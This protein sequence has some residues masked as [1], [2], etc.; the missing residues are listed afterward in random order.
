MEEDVL[1]GL[2]LSGS[3]CLE[4]GPD[5]IKEMGLEFFIRH[6]PVVDEGVKAGGAG[7]I[8]DHEQGGVRIGIFIAGFCGPLAKQLLQA[9]GVV[10]KAGCDIGAEDTHG[11]IVP[12]E[13]Q[14]PDGV[15]QLL[16]HH[17]DQENDG[18]L[19][20]GDAGLFQFPGGFFKKLLGFQSD[21]EVLQIDLVLEVQIEG[22]LG[23]ACL[24]GNLGHGH[25]VDVLA[26]KQREGCRKDFFFFFFLVL[27][28]F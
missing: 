14:Q 19:E 9:V 27:E 18:I 2:F 1:A 4:N 3:A 24:F 8:H 11:E 28:N 26:G 12:D 6:G 20:I 15:F 13:V 22:A 5:G 23:N 10:F 17:G 16:D 21:E 7:Q 25:I